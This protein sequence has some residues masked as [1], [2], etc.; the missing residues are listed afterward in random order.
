MVQ[1]LL[2]RALCVLLLWQ[3]LAIAASK[4]KTPPAAAPVLGLEMD[5]GRRLLFERSFSSER[6][7]KTKH[8][9]LSRLVDLVAGEAEMH[10][11]VR[12]YGVVTDS[13]DRIVIAD[14]GAM[15]LHIVDFAQQKYKF[16]SHR[17]GKDALT[18]PQ[19]VAVD[20]QDNIYVTDSEAGKVFVFNAAGKYQ[21]AI[22]SLKGGEGFFKRPTGIAVDSD[23]QRIFV[24]DTWRDRIFVMDMAGHV[25]Q[26][27]GKLGHGDGEF[28]YP[29]ELRLAGDNLVVVDSMNF[30]VQVLSRTGFFRFAIGQRG[31]GSGQLFRPKGI[32]LDSEDHLYVADAF[33]H[34]VQVFDE[35]GR[36]LYYFGQQGTAPQA[37]QTPAG[38]SID[39]NDRIFVVD[40]TGCRLQVFRYYGLAKPVVGGT[41]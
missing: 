7:F 4:P 23:A 35:Q 5:G 29:T 32:G 41:R 17:E 18:N 30:R 12:P 14:P 6:E 2:T 31:D 34:L 8:S 39:R 38:L 26:T 36:L 13:H 24:A 16:L 11:L 25:L 3:S 37:L 22:G 9:I 28:N 19:C 27:I 33:N 1:F 15:G 20:K 40:S 10:Y 21:R